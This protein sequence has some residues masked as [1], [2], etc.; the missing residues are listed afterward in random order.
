[1]EEGRW[2]DARDAFL[3]IQTEYPQDPIASVAELYI[4]RAGLKDFQVGPLDLRTALSVFSGLAADENVDGRVRF[5]A[6]IYQATTMVLL[7]DAQAALEY[8]GREGAATLSPT[9]LKTDRE[10]AWALLVEALQQNKRY[11]D[12]MVALDRAWQE[13]ETTEL[14]A[15][16]TSRA[17]EV[18][19]MV[20]D[21]VADE[22][23]TASSPVL[24]GLAS[25]KVA[26]RLADEGGDK[27]A[28]Q[29]LVQR[30]VADL[31]S[32]GEDDRAA[33]IAQ[34]RPA[35][36][37]SGPLRIGVLLPQSGAN[38][39][40]GARAMRGA[41]LARDAFGTRR[42]DGITLVMEDSATDVE[43]AMRRLQD[44]GV[45]AIIGPLDAAQARVVATT[46]R[47]LQ[48]P[49]LALTNEIPLEEDSWVF[50][51][52]LDAE[53]EARLMANIARN[54]LK[55]DRAHIVF[56]DIGYGR[57]M[58]TAFRTE[59][60]K[61]GGQVVLAEPYDRTAKDFS[62]LAG[63]V[64]SAQAGAIFIPDAGAK[65]AEITAFLAAKNIWGQAHDASP[66]RDNRTYVHYLGTSLWQDETLTRQAGDYVRGAILPVW[67][68]ATLPYPKT[69]T[70]FQSYR[71]NWNS[72]PGDLEAFTYDSVSLIVEAI[73]QY[74]AASP[75][76]IRTLLTDDTAYRGVTG[77]VKFS[78]TGA[79][80]RTPHIVELREQFTPLPESWIPKSEVDRRLEED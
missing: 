8:L 20:P 21:N 27:D 34:L 58:S 47:N 75:R 12:A 66:V 14:K 56:P 4:A 23:L 64:A 30:A 61:L 42:A 37:L 74:G 5:A 60:E 33:Q 10:D 72:D 39:A 80:L 1:M 17:F 46:A 49:V 50:R 28:L 77:D 76:A 7:G 79:P 73:E 69:Q 67:V 65:V 53:A 9:I 78:A 31:K 19:P 36:T 41:Y 43:A 24:R 13:A 40:V 22:W 48:L 62:K 68:S 18:M 16:V 6:K 44:A 70:F 2:D 52:F 26:H 51:N 55:H 45:S 54:Q 63:K 38:A 11:E 15:F 57:R 71:T 35:Q 59:F 3:A 25:W 29:D 32:L